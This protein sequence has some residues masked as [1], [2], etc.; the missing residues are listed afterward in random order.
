VIPKLRPSDICR[1]S[2][3]DGTGRHCLLGWLRTIV[4][5]RERLAMQQWLAN[6]IERIVGARIG[7]VAFNDQWPLRVVAET[8][9]E[10]R[11]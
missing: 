10:A 7:P 9:N 4:N 6:G 11:A 1:R 2:L 8:W 3:D 5:F